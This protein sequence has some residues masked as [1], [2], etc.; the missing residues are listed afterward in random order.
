V[1][2]RP[3]L[4]LL[5]SVLLLGALAAAPGAGAATRADARAFAKATLAFDLARGRAVGRA[6]R[7]GDER[8]VAA[9]GCLT[10][11]QAAPAAR[12]AELLGLYRSW[13]A[14]GYFAEDEETFA[15]WVRALKRV[16]TRDAALRSARA[17]LG[18]QLTAARSVYGQGRAFCAPVERWAVGGWGAASRPTV[19]RRLKELRTSLRRAP[20]RAGI[21]RAADRLRASGGEGGEL[22]ASALRAGID[23]PDAVVLER[24]DPVVA[25]LD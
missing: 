17:S 25:L 19:V 3:L 16:P 22:A 13:V 9:R 15:R 18:R 10:T 4:P 5:A 6:E 20:L 14:A 11:L 2:R 21:A 1:F 7:R 24:D 23:E 12:H 8:R